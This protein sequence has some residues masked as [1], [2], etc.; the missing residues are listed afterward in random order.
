[1]ERRKKIKTKE[2]KKIKLDGG[3]LLLAV[4]DKRQTDLSLDRA[5]KREKTAKI[6]QN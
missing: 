5:P 3:Q 6:R 4:T 2:D 1:M